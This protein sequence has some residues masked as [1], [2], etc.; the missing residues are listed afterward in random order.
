VK[1]GILTR[2][3]P[4]MVLEVRNLTDFGVGAGTMRAG[5]DWLGKPVVYVVLKQVGR[6]DRLSKVLQNA[7]GYLWQ[8]L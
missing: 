7:A 5:E 8:L 2:P 1:H 4:R 6:A 3:K